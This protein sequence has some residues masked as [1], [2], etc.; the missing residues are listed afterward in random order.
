[1]AVV[2]L[3]RIGYEEVAG[4]LVGGVDAWR[5][6]GRALRSFPTADAS[7]LAARLPEVRALDVRPERPEGG[8]PGTLHVPLS[9]LPRRVVELPR[10]REIWTVCGSGRRA[11][12]AAGLLD[13]AGLAVRAVTSGGVR[14]LRPPA[15]QPIG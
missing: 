6:A 8:I 1:E 2:Q 11:T 15:G 3:L 10:D 9:E 5:A 4:V 7:E 12:V 14:D 13:R